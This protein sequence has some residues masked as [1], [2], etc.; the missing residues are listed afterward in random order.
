MDRLRGNRDLVISAVILATLGFS[1][2][3]PGNG[4][5]LDLQK[6]RKMSSC[7]TLNSSRNENVQIVKATHYFN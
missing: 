3:L 1:V 4:Q 6:I 7:F 2:V 5:A